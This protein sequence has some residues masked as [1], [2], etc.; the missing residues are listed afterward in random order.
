MRQL[1]D[2][3][4][5]INPQSN[6]KRLMYGGS[7]EELSRVSVQS[8]PL[9][10]I[11]ETL[12]MP[13]LRAKRPTDHSYIDRIMYPTKGIPQLD[14]FAEGAMARGSGL[15]MDEE[16]RT[17]LF[18]KH[19]FF[20]GAGTLTGLALSA[21]LTG[22]I[23]PKVTG[24]HA[25]S[26]WGTVAKQAAGR[27]A[28]SGA[29][30]GLKE[31][32]DQTA[33]AIGG[34]D[35]DVQ[36]A[37]FKVLT[38]TAFGTGLGRISAIPQ[39]VLRIPFAMGYGFVNAK[40]DQGIKGFQ[41]GGWQG[42]KESIPKNNLEAGITAGV[43]GLFQLLNTKNLTHVYKTYAYN[44]AK[45][46]L[47]ENCIARGWPAEK[48]QRFAERYLQF[49]T[50]KAGGWGKTRIT[51]FDA[52]AKKM[53]EGWRPYIEKSTPTPTPPPQQPTGTSAGSV[54]GVTLTPTQPK[55][56]TDVP[57]GGTD[58]GKG[59]IQIPGLTPDVAPPVTIP[60]ILADLPSETPVP[61]L[62]ID[63]RVNES[64]EMRL[65]A[66]YPD[67]VFGV[68]NG[69]LVLQTPNK[70]TTLEN[71]PREDIVLLREALSEIQKI[72]KESQAKLL[73]DKARKK[74][75]PEQFKLH[76]EIVKD[77]EASLGQMLQRFG[78]TLKDLID[79]PSILD[80]A[81]VGKEIVKLGTTPITD[82]D[83][84]DAVN[85]YAKT[86]PDLGR[87]FSKILRKQTGKKPWEEM[88]DAERLI[89]FKE[90]ALQDF[91]V[92]TQEM[93]QFGT[94]VMVN[95]MLDRALDPLDP[96]SGVYKAI[97]KK[98][99]A[100]ITPDGGIKLPP[101]LMPAEIGASDLPPGVEIKPPKGR[102]PKPITGTPP[103]DEQNLIGYMME[104]VN[105]GQ[106]GYRAPV[107]DET[108]AKVWKGFPSTYPK[109]MRNVVSKMY[110]KFTKK[111]ALNIL[112]KASQGMKLTDKQQRIYN[113]MKQDAL[114]DF[115][116]DYGVTQIT[117]PTPVEPPVDTPVVGTSMDIIPEAPITK[118][119][120]TQIV[121]KGLLPEPVLWDQ[122]RKAAQTHAK[123]ISDI[124]KFTDY[125]FEELMPKGDYPGA[126]AA[127][128][129]VEMMNYKFDPT[130]HDLK[131]WLNNNTQAA[132]QRTI[133]RLRVDSNNYYDAENAAKYKKAQTALIKET[134]REPTVEEI[135]QKAQ[136]LK[137]P[138]ENLARAWDIK[139]LIEAREGKLSLQGL[140]EEGYEPGDLGAL[141][142]GASE[143][144][145]EFLSI[146]HGK[147]RGEL[148][149]GIPMAEGPRAIEMP[150]LVKMAKELMGND[151]IVRR[152]AGAYGYHKA[153]QI[154]ID[155]ENFKNP[156][157]AA[158]VIAHE[159]GHLYDW[160]PERLPKGI[161]DRGN[162]I[163]RVKTLH[164]F[165]K[166]TFGELKDDV[167]RDELKKLT[168]YWHPF[169]PK[170]QKPSYTTYRYS[171]K[172]L[173]AD[174]ISVLISTPEKAKE[175]APT[176]TQA[177]W[178]SIDK[179]PE[180]AEALL[181][182]NEFLLGTPQQKAE[183]RFEDLHKSY[184][185]AEH[186][187]F[188]ARNRWQMSKRNLLW[189]IKYDLFDKN[190]AVRQAVGDFIKKGGQ[191]NPEDDPRYYLEEFN[192]LGGKIKNLLA[193]TQ[194]NVMHPLMSLGMDMNEA[195]TELGD[196]LFF[197]R[198][199][200]E[201]TE[202]ANPHGHTPKTA[203]DMLTAQEQKLGPEKWEVLKQSIEKFREQIGSLIQ[204]AEKSGLYGPELAERLMLNPAYATFQILDYIDDYI[205]P[206]II[207]QRGTFKGIANPF[208]ATTIKMTSLVRAIER[209]NVR[210]IVAASPAIDKI[211]AKVV[212][213][214]AKGPAHISHK[215][216][217]GIIRYMDGGKLKAVYTDPYVA[218][219]VNY[220][221]TPVSK[222]ILQ[223][224]RWCNR[225][226]FRPIYIHWNVGF[227]FHNFQRDF[228]RSWKMMGNNVPIWKAI[229]I[230]QKAAPIAAG[231][232]WGK[233]QPKEIT[234]MQQNG[235]LSVTFNDVYGDNPDEE[236]Q[237]EY[238]LKKMGIVQAGAREGW[239]KAQLGK[240]PV[241]NK[242]PKF[243]DKI[244]EAGNFIET[245]SKVAGYMARKHRVGDEGYKQIA[246]E[247]RTMSGTPD[248]LTR[249][250]WSAVTNELFL[251]SNVY[252][253]GFRG[254]YEGAFR[255]PNTR[256]GYWW[257]TLKL[258][259]IPALLQRLASQG[260]FGDEVKEAYDHMSE[261]DKS[262]FVCIPLGWTEDNKIIYIRI[263]HDEIS[264]MFAATIWNAT[265]PDMKSLP[266]YF[267]GLFQ[268]FAGMVPSL[269][270]TAEL[271]TVWGTYLFTPY[272]P[273]D[274]SGR[275]VMS[276]KERKAEAYSGRKYSL[277]RMIKWTAGKFGM[278]QW[279]R[280]R[281]NMSPTE[282]LL[283][284]LPA[285]DRLI[286]V[287]DRGL[288]EI[289][290][291]AR[292]QKRGF[293]A[294][295][296]LEKRKQRYGY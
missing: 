255:N 127:M 237:Y 78:L 89:E 265:S 133:M 291:K 75:T 162:L 10:Q 154:V 23:A 239:V 50:H 270:P 250:K 222:G 101:G 134:Q 67:D 271:M 68:E 51:D 36:D 207:E 212:R 82:K 213:F 223:A 290:S 53:R 48:A 83:L 59:D 165:L 251:F 261:F 161:P 210:K 115:E 22:G 34:E 252:I 100:T 168:Q 72:A 146:Q 15:D 209:N 121:E 242:L 202:L 186:G 280:M 157:W 138:K 263:P 284:W 243:M 20:A 63:T 131:K 104:M 91:K 92:A 25:L 43:Y 205:S 268:P 171:G 30:F 123:K 245:W 60:G 132:V 11:W 189:H 158:A 147:Q 24:A 102:K 241:L 172:E 211:P 288:R 199:L 227:M 17:E 177:F 232:I 38:K 80:D 55:P 167:F 266:D 119:N 248:H 236:W 149:S 112:N 218:D 40:I 6:Q 2:L 145:V 156:V 139:S 84:I 179:K 31:L 264:R 182:M 66:K 58:I 285:I 184:V 130:K 142:P 296:S 39:P 286:K 137:D 187:Y 193:W 191:I 90:F 169:D 111:E 244:E 88:T 47:A 196:Y 148:P 272:A 275:P 204:S 173:Y 125:N 128:A 200:N 249:G 278:F 143:E 240:V 274:L 215:D 231:R 94:P 208:T 181:K 262:H 8:Q 279:Q 74:L 238:L 98:A 77:E 140:A 93:G 4:E 197:D 71:A 76:S 282:K 28:Q 295:R 61:G 194:E 86:A 246:H 256:Q 35:V 87:A 253:Q 108:G 175:I 195:Q 170:A 122:L 135:A 214:G 258:A 79:N 95:Y 126:L 276:D 190:Y 105:M 141:L 294:M 106:P 224:F 29:T 124:A 19:P 233:F 64:A 110:P 247:V 163:G 180:V 229:E 3:W 269:N 118:Y 234:E 97:L 54:P 18:A 44:G 160:L 69:K 219:T 113:A 216:G 293:D 164:N 144:E 203:Q 85:Q 120:V 259:I 151:I 33:K 7:E 13:S 21:K 9:Q 228:K 114:P 217:Y 52:F 206:M 45:Q 109:F 150:E 81:L 56:M 225:E 57:I 192:Y 159:M 103:T 155:P 65:R 273:T 14:A 49:A 226:L 12:D 185:N 174:F 1:Q 201:R 287:S 136:F 289:E 198:V 220:T 188:A 26:T 41:E 27:M 116:K 260:T 42:V 267:L 221:P 257:R 32:L 176:F 5:Q 235:M 277:P 283:N 166:H 70:Y 16:K 129:W 107:E 153:G 178:D 73:N 292:E 96:M 281:D 230:F 37:A 99:G 117:P 46:A 152:I 62:E 183:A 254:D